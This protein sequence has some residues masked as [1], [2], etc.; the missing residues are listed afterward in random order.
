MGIS[1]KED[2]QAHGI[3]KP[4]MITTLVA[5]PSLKNLLFHLYLFV[6]LFLY[7]YCIFSHSFIRMK[8]MSCLSEY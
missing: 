3:S 5:S 1:T 4:L 2:I 7:F 8:L 6:S